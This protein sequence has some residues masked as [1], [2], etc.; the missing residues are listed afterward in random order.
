M[1]L[2]ETKKMYAAYVA[3]KKKKRKEQPVH[4]YHV[5]DKELDIVI[6]TK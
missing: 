4:N 2:K 6:E 1:D 3:D 5:K